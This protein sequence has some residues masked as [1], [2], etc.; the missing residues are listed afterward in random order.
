MFEGFAK[1]TAY[2]VCDCVCLKGMRVKK[3]KFHGNMKF[4]ILI[5]I[6][7]KLLSKCLYIIIL[8][9]YYIFK[10]QYACVCVCVMCNPHHILADFSTITVILAR[11]DN[12][13][14]MSLL[15]AAWFMTTQN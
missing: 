1:G 11:N 6:C 13:I 2:M 7:H 5:L 8:Y 9:V 14:C 15:N 4:D 12:F 3:E 10:K